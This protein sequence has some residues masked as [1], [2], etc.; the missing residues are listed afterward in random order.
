MAGTE[1]LSR[2]SW[3]QPHVYTLVIIFYPPTQHTEWEKDS[4]KN[5]D[6]TVP[7]FPV[8]KLQSHVHAK[9]VK[10]GFSVFSIEQRRDSPLLNL[11]Y[12]ML[13]KVLMQN[14]SVKFDWIT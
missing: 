3:A 8:C 5:D 6:S 10:S 13:L 4:A 11:R 9:P 1:I 14:A 12:Q 2:I 7:E